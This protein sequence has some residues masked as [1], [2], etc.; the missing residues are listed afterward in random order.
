MSVYALIGHTKCRRL[1]V[2]TFVGRVLGAITLRSHTYEDVEADRQ[3]TL[4]AVVIVV[5]ASVAGGIGSMGLGVRSTQSVAVGTLGALIGWVAWAVLT[6]VIGTR[7]L[8]EPQTRATVGELL[9]TLGFA[10]APGLLRVFG[11]IPLLGLVLYGLASVWMLIAMVVAVRHALDYRST[12]RALGVC[13][14]GW[15]LSLI[16]A[17]IIGVVFTTDVS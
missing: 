9:R 10:A 13:V 3:A 15:V 1:S 7:L 14:T 11:A 12:T 6:Y 16:I 4:Q 8:P 5:L 2:G 17:A